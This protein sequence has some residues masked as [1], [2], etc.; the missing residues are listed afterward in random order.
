M[1]KQQWK[2]MV[3]DTRNAMEQIVVEEQRH[4]ENEMTV[5]SAYFR[6]PDSTSLAYTLKSQVVLCYQP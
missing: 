1:K 3:N 2:L 6:S 5:I 4:R